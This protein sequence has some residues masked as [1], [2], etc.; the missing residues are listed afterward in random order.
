[1]PTLK[2]LWLEN[3]WYFYLIDDL[4]YLS[5]GVINLINQFNEPVAHLV[6]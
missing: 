5:K 6:V 1:M 4:H 3:V 2:R